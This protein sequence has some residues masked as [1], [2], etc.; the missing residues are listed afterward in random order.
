MGGEKEK[1]GRRVGVGGW[2]GNRTGLTD[3]SIGTQWSLKKERRAR[4]MKK[5]GK[6]RGSAG[7]GGLREVAKLDW[8]GG[9]DSKRLPGQLEAGRAGG[10]RVV[11]VVMSSIRYGYKKNSDVWSVTPSNGGRDAKRQ[12]EERP[13]GTKRVG[14]LLNVEIYLQQQY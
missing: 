7:R 5:I 13:G 9:G 8:S 3:S 14:C 6:R 10:R 1:E 2:G 4:K 12:E 11:T